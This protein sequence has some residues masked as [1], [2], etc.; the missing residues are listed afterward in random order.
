[1]GAF[2]SGWLAEDGAKAIVNWPKAVNALKGSKGSM[3]TAPITS[4]QTG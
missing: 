3:R 4:H 1:M 2:V